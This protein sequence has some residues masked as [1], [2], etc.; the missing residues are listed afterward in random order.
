[1]NR[2]CVKQIL[3]LILIGIS[4]F[5]ISQPQNYTLLTGTAKTNIETK[6]KTA[7]QN[8]L[9]MQCKFTQKKTSTLF[10][11]EAVSKGLLFYKS[12]NSLRWQYTEPNPLTLIFHKDNAY[13][14]DE[15][16]TIVNSNK[17]LKQLGDFI[18]SNINGNGLTDNGNFKIDYYANEKDKDKNKNIVWIKLTPV[19]RRLKEMYVSIQI[20]MSTV[21]Y[22]AIEIIMEEISGD[23]TTITFSDKK[24]NVNIPDSQFSTH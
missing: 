15:K 9:S 13:I 4:F 17:M 11:E 3:S 8:I 20:K 10:Q 14:Q 23:K 24:I 7:S 6:I 1:M 21:D 5:G 19:V 2:K 18:I 22:L 12:P 16:G